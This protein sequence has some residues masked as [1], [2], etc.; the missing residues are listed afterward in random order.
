MMMAVA[1]NIGRATCRAAL[2]ASRSVR[3]ASGRLFTPMAYT[4]GYALLGA[5]LCA[6]L[7]AP[8]NVFDHDDGVVHDDAEIDRT[9]GQQVRRGVRCRH[10]DERDRQ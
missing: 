2:R 4:V 8:E 6:L 1:K 7:A 9:E 3:T 10:Q 5:A